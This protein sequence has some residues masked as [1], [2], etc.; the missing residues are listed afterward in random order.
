MSPKRIIFL[1][2]GLLLATFIVQ[3]ADAVPVKFLFWGSQVSM[4]LILMGSFVLGAIV[5]WV[6]G[7]VYGRERSVVVSATKESSE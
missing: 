4:A 6:S 1:V 5:G 2:L 7:R 3:N